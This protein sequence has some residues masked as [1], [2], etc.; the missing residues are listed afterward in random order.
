MAYGGLPAPPK[1]SD[2]PSGVVAAVLRVFVRRG[3]QDVVE[4][5]LADLADACAA[6]EPGCL[7]FEVHRAI[8][9]DRAYVVYQRFASWAAMEVHGDTAHVRAAFGQIMPLAETPPQIEIFTELFSSRRA[10]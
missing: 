1:P 10:T 8:G 9:T 5:A 7:Q 2:V 4:R 3:A 6:F